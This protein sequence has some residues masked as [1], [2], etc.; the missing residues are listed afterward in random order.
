MARRLTVLIGTGAIGF[1]AVLAVACTTGNSA[2]APS[3]QP[4]TGDGFAI[5]VPEEGWEASDEGDQLVP[6][7]LV[8]YLPAGEL[9]PGSVPPQIGVALDRGGE[10]G[11]PSD[12]DAY[13]E[14]LFR[15]GPA[16]ADRSVDIADRREVDVD[17]AEPAMRVEVA[18]T[19]EGADGAPRVRMKLLLV[20]TAEGPIW[21]VRYAATDA[22]F[23]DALAE[24]VLDSFELR[25]SASA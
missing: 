2:E 13:I 21:D 9:E 23:D 24:A 11:P 5:G 1:V 20:R 15:A 4:V 22:D 3:L 25:G 16:L 17:G 7:R 6:G 18:Y 19:A 8:E 12:L 14:L 10:S